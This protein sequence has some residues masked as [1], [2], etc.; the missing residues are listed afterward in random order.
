MAAKILPLY[1]V[2]QL[3]RE[4]WTEAPIT[5]YGFEVAVLIGIAIVSVV[6][7]TLRFLF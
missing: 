2:V 1:Y 4:T 7:A 3:L 6:L 5:E